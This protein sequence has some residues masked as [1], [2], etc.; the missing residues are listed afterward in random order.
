MTNYSQVGRGH[1]RV[2]D[3]K[4]LGLHYIFVIGE[5]VHFKFDMQIDNDRSLHV[6]DR[7]PLKGGL[8]RSCDLF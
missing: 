4:I 7:L 8:F 3:F 1:G 6:C 5:A 2:T